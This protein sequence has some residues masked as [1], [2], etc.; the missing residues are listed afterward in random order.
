M[1][2]KKHEWVPANTLLSCETVTYL[3]C[4]RCGIVQNDKNVD[5]LC[6]GPAKITVRKKKHD[7]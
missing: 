5:K 6:K 1:N 7:I 3:V 2:T 4:R